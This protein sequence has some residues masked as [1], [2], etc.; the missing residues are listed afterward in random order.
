MNQTDDFRT[1]LGE[2]S[3]IPLSD[4]IFKLI[5]DNAETLTFR[6]GET[7]VDTR[8]FHLRQK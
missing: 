4:N 7:V 2:E 5:T 6:K 8:L 3:D 1:A